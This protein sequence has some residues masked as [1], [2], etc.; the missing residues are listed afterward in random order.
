MSFERNDSRFC[1]Y[2]NSIHTNDETS[3]VQQ[4]QTPTTRQT[5]LFNNLTNF[6]SV[7]NTYFY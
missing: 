4:Q 7:V 3:F 6:F 5:M 2:N 1:Q